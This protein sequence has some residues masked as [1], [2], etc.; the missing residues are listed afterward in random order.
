MS[1]IQKIKKRPSS[2]VLGGSYFFG[3]MWMTGP[4]I[5]VVS[6]SPTYTL[7]RNLSVFMVGAFIVF[8][9]YRMNKRPK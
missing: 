5:D 9:T 7:P 4:L 2:I 3:A 6:G 1:E 8:S